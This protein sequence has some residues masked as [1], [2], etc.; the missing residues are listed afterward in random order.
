MA[1]NIGILP[2]LLGAAANNLNNN[3]NNN[4]NNNNGLSRN[5]GGGSSNNSGGG[6]PMNSVRDRLF[7]ALFVRVALAYASAVPPSVRTLFEYITLLKALLSFFILAYIHAAFIR[8]PI[9]CLEHVCHQWPQDGILRIEIIHDSA[10]SSEPYTVEQSYLKEQ[11]L[12]RLGQLPAQPQVRTSSSGVEKVISTPPL[13]D[14]SN[15]TSSDVQDDQGAERSASTGSSGRD[16]GDDTND[17]PEMDET[18]P[19]LGSGR[20]LKGVKGGGSQFVYHDGVSNESQ[21]TLPNVDGNGYPQ[22]LQE[23]V[24]ELEMLARAVWPQDEYIVEYSLEYGL[25]RLSPATRQKLNISVKIV[26]LDPA[27]DGC[28]GDWFSRFLLDGFLGYDDVLMASLKNLAEREENKGYVRNVVT[29]EHYRFISM[30]TSRTSYIAA[31]FIMLVFTLSI[32]M[33]LRYSHHQ[34]FVFIVELLH[35]LE[36]NS[37]INFPAGPLLTVILALVGMETIMSEFFNDTTTAFYIILIVWVAD[38]YDAICCHTAITK[39]HWLRFFYLYHFA[40]YAYDYRF[41]GQYSGLA[42]LTSWFFIQHSMIYFFH[43]YELPS[44]LQRSGGLEQGEPAR[45]GA[46]NGAAGT[47]SSAAAGASGGPVSGGGGTQS[48]ATASQ[49]QQNQRANGVSGPFHSTT[50]RLNGHGAIAI[51]QSGDAP[52]VAFIRTVYIGNLLNAAT[53]GAAATASQ[54]PN[55]QQQQ[56]EQTQSSQQSQSQQQQTQQSP[57]DGSRNGVEE[58][59]TRNGEGDVALIPSGRTDGGAEVIQTSDDTSEN[60]TKLAN[61]GDRVAKERKEST[62]SSCEDLKGE[63]VAVSQN[64]ETTGPEPEPEPAVPDGQNSAPSSEDPPP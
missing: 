9:N 43:H 26:T 28:F 42:L 32:S 3:L 8:T 63:G 33:L 44:I 15:S 41:N 57:N 48:S 6:N 20:H 60:S 59:N 50:V 37:T 62:S 38:Q 10:S 55:Q 47:E 18:L 13:A 36:F 46:T 4:N 19:L 45:A 53:L 35:M 64:D 30:W 1:L 14:D 39:R 7:H 34:I 56:Q 58:A 22:P 2:H 49:Q 16:T 11:R 54:S 51:Q 21:D 29:G 52:R 17:V 31:A 40:F 24:S 27:K 5:A 61:V 23:P 25:L 12:Q